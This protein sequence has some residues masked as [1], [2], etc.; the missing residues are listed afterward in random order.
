[1]AT[2]TWRCRATDAAHDAIDALAYEPLA[3]LGC[4][5]SAE[6]TIGL[7]QKAWLRVSRNPAELAQMR[8]LKQA[9]DPYNILNPSK[10]LS[11]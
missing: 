5:T 1:M 4:A 10:M 6:H 3:A 11:P 9:L 7:D 2:C 8:T